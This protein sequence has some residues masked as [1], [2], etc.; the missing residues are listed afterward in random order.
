MATVTL[1]DGTTFQAP[2][3]VSAESIMALPGAGNPGGGQQQQQVQ[4]PDLSQL[5]ADAGLTGKQAADYTWSDLLG[6]VYNGNDVPPPNT[7]TLK[8]A[9]DLGTINGQQTLANI[10]QQADLTGMY[11]NNPTLAAQTLMGRIGG[12]MQNGVYTGGTATLDEQ[13]LQN[14]QNQFLANLIS[15]SGKGFADPFSYA[16]KLQGLQQSG[17]LGN[18]L[19]NNL[20]FA[21]GNSLSQLQQAP[22]LTNTQLA[23]DLASAQNGGSVTP[24]TAMFMQRMLGAPTAGG[25]TGNG[26][27][28]PG[29]SPGGVPLG[30]GGQPPTSAALPVGGNSSNPLNS[31]NIGFSTS[32]QQFNRLNPTLQS[33]YTDL[34]GNLPNGQNA[35]DFQAAMK[36]GAP[37][38]AKAGM[39]RLGNVEGL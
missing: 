26:Q 11:N 36:Q 4:Q 15:N 18:L 7:P 34:V 24:A 20:A 17:T 2:D 32:L 31:A 28:F 6:Y 23:T 29:G 38:F 12:T 39:A 21:S 37:E 22:N 9:E 35:A 13:K 10:K 30:N 25:V 19:G 3:S 8:A 14:D 33:A 27:V 1:A 16:A 5:A